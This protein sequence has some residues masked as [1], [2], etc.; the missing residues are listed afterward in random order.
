MRNSKKTGNERS[1]GKENCFASKRKQNKRSLKMKRRRGSSKSARQSYKN[2]N[3][4]NSTERS[5]KS[6]NSNGLQS[7]K[8]VLKPN[9]GKKR[10]KLNRK[11]SNVKPRRFLKLNKKR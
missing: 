7:N 1:L 10:L 5:K 3:R 11:S 6:W 4:L 8:D 2:R 9:R